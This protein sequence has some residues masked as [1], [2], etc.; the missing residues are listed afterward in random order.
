MYNLLMNRNRQAKQDIA[1]YASDYH[2]K[3]RSSSG[4]VS[5]DDV[6][7]S[8]SKKFENEDSNKRTQKLPNL[9]LPSRNRSLSK[10]QSTDKRFRR[11]TS[12]SKLRPAVLDVNFQKL[13]AIHKKKML[14]L[15]QENLYAATYQKRCLLQSSPSKHDQSAASG[16]WKDRQLFDKNFNTMEAAKAS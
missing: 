13:P 16:Y 14:L 11:V 15:N 9:A 1:E 4:L 7:L 6:S 3:M 8:N 2:R 5:S 12:S 10:D